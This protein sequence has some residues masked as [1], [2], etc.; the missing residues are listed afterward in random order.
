MLSPYKV[1]QGARGPGRIGPAAA[2]PG[3]LE[4][5]V[6][7]GEPVRAV[8]GPPDALR[9]A[10]DQFGVRPVPEGLDTAPLHVRERQAQVY[11]PQHAERQG[12]DYLRGPHLAGSAPT[13]EG[14]DVPP[15]AALIQG[16][17]PG[18]QFEVRGQSLPQAARDRA[19]AL[20]GGVTLVAA[21]EDV[22]VPGNG[23]DQVDQVE[24]RLVGRLQPVLGDVGH[25]DQGAQEGGHVGLAQ[26]LVEGGAVQTGS[27]P[28][29]AV[30]HEGDTQRRQV[31]ADAPGQGTKGLQDLGV[32][33]ETA[34][35]LEH[36]GDQVVLHVV[37]EHVT[38]CHPQLAR[39]PPD[40][41]VIGVDE[42]SAQLHMLAPEDAVLGEHAPAHPVTCLVDSHRHIRLPQPVGRR[43]A[44]DARPHDDHRVVPVGCPL[45]LQADRSLR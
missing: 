32:G 8:A 40:S 31:R 44:R 17:Q 13:R 3:R 21:A 39:Q 28:R 41:L 43:E 5:P 6:R 7:V 9:E 4:G 27:V 10:R 23:A 19:V 30:G 33:V 42:F 2:L 35:K 15:V 38:Q 34:A 37:G 20:L 24:A 45:G 16:L 26:V 18:I 29:G 12:Q 14:Q 22:E 1:R 36:L 25:L 11:P